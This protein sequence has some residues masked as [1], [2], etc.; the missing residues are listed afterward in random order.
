MRPLEIIRSVLLSIASNKFRVFLTS[1]GIIIG[2]LTII[3]VV[4][5]G[6]AGE[7]AVAEQYS[8]LSVESI[9]I[10]R[11][12]GMGQSAASLPVLDRADALLMPEVLPNVKSIGMATRVV[13]D[14]AANG[15][16]SSITIQGITEEYAQIT[17]L[18]TAFG[19]MLTN[20]DSQMRSRYTVLGHNIASDLFDQDPGSAVGQTVLIKGSSFEV[21]G[22]LDRVGGTGGV[23][24]SSPADSGSVDDMA[25]LPYDVA[26]K[27]TSGTTSRNPT[28]SAN[29]VSFIALA[30]DISSVDAAIAEIKE[31]LGETLGSGEGYTVTDAGNVLESAQETAKTLSG[32]LLAV[33]VIVLVVSGIGIMNVLLVAVNERTREIGIL[34]SIGAS[35]RTIMVEFL[36]EA[37]MI[38]IFG[39]LLGA[40]FSLAAPQLLAMTDLAFEPSFEGILL[41]IGFS[42]VTGIFFGF[43]P[44]A[45]AS[46]L[47]P[48]DAL[49]YE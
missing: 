31:Y 24:S 15:I 49:N 47:E 20:E 22:V 45:K 46:G 48:I 25:F 7:T 10:A 19:V 4:G 11:V 14:I 23:A 18:R 26:V 33:A 21:I 29:Q 30:Q 36:L 28:S 1:L 3:L 17:R 42:V 38:S 27:Y 37:A 41:G 6:K 32:L 2:T 39:G 40:T 16:S 9:T 12:R 44:A 8:R 43:Y 13:A 34:K 5:I 35:R